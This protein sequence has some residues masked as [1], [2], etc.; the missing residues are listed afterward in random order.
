MARKTF[1]RMILNGIRDILDGQWLVKQTGFRSVEYKMYSI[2]ILKMI[3]QY[4]KEFNQTWHITYMLQISES[5]MIW[6]TVKNYGRNV[7]YMNYLVTRTGRSN[8][9]TETRESKCEQTQANAS[10]LIT[11]K[12]KY[13]CVFIRI[14]F[15]RYTGD[16]IR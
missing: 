1:V 3:V 8:C 10:I 2:F 12:V 9:C 14:V 4:Q 13:V 5:L 11:I 7:L 6:F 16:F 15:H